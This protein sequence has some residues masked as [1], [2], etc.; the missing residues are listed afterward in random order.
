MVSARSFLPSA[1]GTSPKHSRYDDDAKL[2]DRNGLDRHGRAT[3]RPTLTE[4]LCEAGIS[5]ECKLLVCLGV[6]I[7]I[8]ISLYQVMGQ[9][10][11][12]FVIPFPSFVGNLLDTT[13]T[14]EIERESCCR[15]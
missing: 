11:G 4:K 1:I 13:E 3:S 9:M 5:L 2:Y 6:K 7:K 15:P 10:S 12:T 14:V 8:L